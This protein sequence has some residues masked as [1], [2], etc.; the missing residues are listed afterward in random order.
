[1]AEPK[2]RG[3]FLHETTFLLDVQVV[4]Y[5]AKKKR[6]S[7]PALKGA[8]FLLAAIALFIL[9]CETRKPR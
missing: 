4:Y 1:M 9:D 2:E 5:Y 6:I 3:T 7:K 8:F